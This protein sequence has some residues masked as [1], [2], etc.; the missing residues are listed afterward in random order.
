MASDFRWEGLDGS[1]VLCHWMPLGYRAGL[2][3]TQLQK[4]YEELKKHAATIRHIFMPSGSGVTLPQPE[5]PEIVEKWNATMDIKDGAPNGKSSMNTLSATTGTDTFTA[6]GTSHKNAKKPKIRISTPSEY[7]SNLEKAQVNEEK[8]KFAIRTGEMYS[9]RLSEVFP[10]CTSSRMWIKQGVK[11]Y[12]NL[13]LTLERWHA[14]SEVEGVDHDISDRLKNYWNRLLFMSMHDALPG[15]G[16]DEI[17][18]EI[19]QSFKSDFGPIRK[20]IVHCLLNLLS[21]FCKGS[22]QDLVVFNSH[23]WKVKDWV[24]CV[25]EFDE[26]K[27][28]GIS[29]LTLSNSFNNSTG[30]QSQKVRNK[31]KVSI[32]EGENRIDIE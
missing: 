1:R 19:R 14:L 5:T 20:L 27:I 18:N 9:G 10:D 17:Y 4:S 28:R 6:T 32:N 15:T 23:A 13:L 8:V 21:H 31:H 3:L 22:D 16:I 26:G 24:E 11:A 12:E 7:F 25:L 30:I 29:H 2:D